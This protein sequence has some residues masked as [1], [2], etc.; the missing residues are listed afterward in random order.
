LLDN[1]PL[2]QFDII[3]VSF[4]SAETIAHTLHSVALQKGVRSNHILIDGNSEDATL[5]IVSDIGT[6]DLI[7][8]ENDR[9]I[10]DALN[11]GLNLTNA[12]YVGVLHS[13]DVFFDDYVLHSVALAFDQDPEIDIVYGNL[14]YTDES[15]KSIK[16][17]WRDP[18]TKLGCK[19]G[20]MPPHPATFYRKTF[21]D[22]LGLYSLDYSISAD[23]EYLLRAIYSHNANIAH[24]DKFLVKMRTGGASNKSIKNIILKTLQDI[25]ILRAS[26]LLALP[27]IIFKY[28]RKLPQLYL[29]K[30]YFLQRRSKM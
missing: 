6:V 15:L 19:Y 14:V 25:R 16:R 2:P 20:W 27:T 30:K 1:T 23:Y 24:L 22:R 26:P 18:S 7:V 12:E 8:S 4:N 5:N 3:T 13:N 29:S 17:V 21:L 10:Y 11:K 28:L 9:G